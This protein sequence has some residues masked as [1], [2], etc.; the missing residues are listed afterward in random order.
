MYFTTYFGG[1]D[2]AELEAGKTYQVTLAL[3]GNFKPADEGGS[4]GG[5]TEDPTKPTINSSVEVTVTA[6]TWVNGADISKEWL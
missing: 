6:A 2:K 5:G 4:G 3:N 1:G